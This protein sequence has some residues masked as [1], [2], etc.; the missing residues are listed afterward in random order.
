MF[1]N[2]HTPHTSNLFIYLR[3]LYIHYDDFSILQQNVK[4][5]KKYFYVAIKSSF[6][7]QCNTLV[8][9]LISA[10]KIGKK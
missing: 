8:P 6:N 4:F 2:T 9:K 5:I 3:L 1:L 7:Q 10:T